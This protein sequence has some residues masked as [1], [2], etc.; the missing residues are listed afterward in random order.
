MFPFMFKWSQVLSL[1]NQHC[2]SISHR[3]SQKSVSI[4]ICLSWHCRNGRESWTRFNSS[5]HTNGRSLINVDD[6]S[7]WNI[8]F[9]Y[10]CCITQIVLDCDHRPLWTLSHYMETRLLKK[11][12]WCY[13]LLRLICW[14]SIKGRIQFGLYL[15]AEKLVLFHQT[16]VQ[17]KETLQ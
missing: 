2:V 9:P 16:F 7:C 1:E 17:L 12:Y 4:K 6:C 10:V 15:G 3:S 11:P 5:D 14:N 13:I 8:M